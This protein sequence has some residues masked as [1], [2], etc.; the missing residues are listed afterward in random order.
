MDSS[1]TSEILKLNWKE[2]WPSATDKWY[3]EDDQ[4]DEFI[5]IRDWKFHNDK[6]TFKLDAEIGD[7]G[8]IKNKLRLI[9]NTES[10][11]EKVI[12]IYFL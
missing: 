5:D 8:L 10:V 6:A 11:G 4:G 9:S 12:N 3:E 1:D 7:K 2:S